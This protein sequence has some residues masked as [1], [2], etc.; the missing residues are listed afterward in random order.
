MMMMVG[1]NFEDW[2]FLHLHLLLDLLVLVVV[3]APALD[4]G[5]GGDDGGDGGDAEEEE[6]FVPDRC[7]SSGKG[8]N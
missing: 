8:D 1:V 6:D 7:Q 2:A 4:G 3:E 5:D